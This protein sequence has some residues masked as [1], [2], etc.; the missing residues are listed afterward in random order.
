MVVDTQGYSKSNSNHIGYNMWVENL[1]T[2]PTTSM[3]VLSY[4]LPNGCQNDHKR[5]PN[6]GVPRF[7]ALSYQ[8][9]DKHVLQTW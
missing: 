9:Q 2:M 7:I 5:G 4:H 6:G 8:N 3:Q 1:Q